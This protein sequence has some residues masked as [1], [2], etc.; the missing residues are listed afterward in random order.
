MRIILT[1]GTGLIGTPLVKALAA[2][3]HD[4]TVLTRNPDKVK[5]ADPAVKYVKWDGQTSA[6]WGALAD[7]AQDKVPVCFGQFRIPV[8]AVSSSGQFVNHDPSDSGLPVSAYRNSSNIAQNL[9]DA[10]GG[11]RRRFGD[12]DD[13]GGRKQC[14]DRK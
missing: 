1:G 7:G 4:V 11:P 14:V 8:G 9:F 6:G 10:I 5:P 2:D 3:G 12:D 13:I